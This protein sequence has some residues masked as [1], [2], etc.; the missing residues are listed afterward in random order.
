MGKKRLFGLYLINEVSR[1]IYRQD[2]KKHHRDTSFAQKF[3]KNISTAG[4]LPISKFSYS[5]FSDCSFSSSI[6]FTDVVFK[7]LKSRKL[8]LSENPQHDMNFISI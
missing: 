3:F 2:S 8:V 6:R 4:E 7:I 1:K 5:S